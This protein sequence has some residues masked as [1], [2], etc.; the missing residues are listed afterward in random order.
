[1]EASGPS[2]SCIAHRSCIAVS[3]SRRYLFVLGG[4]PK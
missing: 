4:V 3:Q 1:L 2:M